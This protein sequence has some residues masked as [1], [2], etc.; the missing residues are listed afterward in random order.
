MELG[1]RIGGVIW[2]ARKGHKRD[3]Q[4]CFCKSTRGE[5]NGKNNP[6]Y[7]SGKNN[8]MYGLIGENNPNYGRKNSEETKKKIIKKLHQFLNTSVKRI[9]Q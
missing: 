9:N 4:C 8:P 7:N 3:C 2:L 5:Y 1:E 6:M